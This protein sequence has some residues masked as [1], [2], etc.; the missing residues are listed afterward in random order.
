LRSPINYTKD[1]LV[2]KYV[3]NKLA[4]PTGNKIFFLI[5]KDIYLKKN[6]CENSNNLKNLINYIGTLYVE[7]LSRNRHHHEY[8]R[9]K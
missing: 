6:D 2:A 8:W 5:D 4:T 3:V 1:F 7:K 9:K